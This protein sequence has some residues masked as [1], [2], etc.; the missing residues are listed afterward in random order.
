MPHKDYRDLMD[1]RIANLDQKITEG[2]KLTRERIEDQL[3][4]IYKDVVITREHAAHTN[5]RVNKHDLKLEKMEESV[6][7]LEKAIAEN[8]AK[9]ETCPIHEVKKDVKEMEKKQEEKEEKLQ[10]L[11]FFLRHPKLA[12]AIL[13]GSV[14]ITILAVLAFI[15][16]TVNVF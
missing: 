4:L 12:N 7:E 9:Y 5:S 1:E 16:K 14:I 2:F 10:D 3:A 6:V 13:T 8:K 11:Y 15:F